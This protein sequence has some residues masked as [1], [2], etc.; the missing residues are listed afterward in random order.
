MLGILQVV[1]NSLL[2]EQMNK[3]IQIL[4]Q[5]LMSHALWALPCVILS[6]GPFQ[7]ET[8]AVASL[9]FFPTR[10]FFFLPLSMF[11]MLLALLEIPSTFSANVNIFSPPMLIAPPALP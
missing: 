10:M 4:P 9:V 5:T 2:D 3:R 8:Y 1:R 11:L 6:V 7:L